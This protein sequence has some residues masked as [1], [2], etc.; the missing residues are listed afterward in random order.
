MYLWRAI[1]SK[2]E[3]LDI[4]IQSGKD[5]ATALKAMRTLLRK[6]GF[7]SKVLVTDKLPPYR[8]ALRELAL[9]AHHEQGLRK[10][11]RTEN[12][13]EVMRRRERKMEGF[14]WSRLDQ[15][16]PSVH[17][18]DYKT[19]SHQRFLISRRTLR[20]FRAAAAEQWANAAAAA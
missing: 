17:A 4:L 7:A 18:P 15:R 10:N 14:K 12:S 2:G 1:D 6:Q 5:K 13:H 20:L 3:I 8:A 9:T 16:L 19:F 11:K